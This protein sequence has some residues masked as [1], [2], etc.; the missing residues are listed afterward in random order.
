DQSDWSNKIAPCSGLTVSWKVYKEFALALHNSKTVTNVTSMEECQNLCIADLDLPCL[1]VDFDS[2]GL[3]CHLSQSS[4]STAADYLLPFARF[5]HA[6][7]YCPDDP[8]EEETVSWTSTEQRLRG[9]VVAENYDVWSLQEC[10]NLCLK[11]T[12][13]DGIAYEETN[14]VCLLMAMLTINQFDIEAPRWISEFYTCENGSDSSSS[15]EVDSAFVLATFAGPGEDIFTCDFLNVS[16]QNSQFQYNVLWN[17]NGE[18]IS[19]EA[20][21]IFTLPR[22]FSDIS[23]G[24]MLQCGVSVCEVENC[25][26]TRGPLVFSNFYTA[27]IQ[28]NTLRNQ[29][30]GE[31]EMGEVIQVRATAPPYVLCRGKLS[32]SDDCSIEVKFSFEETS[33]VSSCPNGS[34]VAQA[35]LLVLKNDGKSN[36]SLGVCSITL[37]NDDWDSTFFVRAKG[38]FDQLFDGD[39]IIQQTTSVDYLNST[40]TVH[41]EQVG[42]VQLTIVDKDNGA[43]CSSVTDPHIT[44]FDGRLFH[45]FLEGEFILYKHQTLPYEVRSFYR[46]CADITDVNDP[47]ASCNCAVAIRAGDD[48]VIFDKCGPTGTN[49]QTFYPM[50]AHMFRK[51]ILTPGF[52]VISKYEGRQYKVIFPSGLIVFVAS[53]PFD[54]L[55]ILNIWIKPSPTDL[56][57]TEGLCGPYDL[58]PSNDLMFQNGTVYRDEGDYH[59]PIDYM[60]SWRVDPADTLYTGSCYQSDDEDVDVDSVVTFCQCTNSGENTCAPES[61]K[62]TCPYMEINEVDVTMRL[63]RQASFPLKCLGIPS[64]IDDL[65]L[66]QFEENYGLQVIEPKSLWENLCSAELEEYDVFTICNNVPGIRL[67]AIIE[68]CG[69][70]FLIEAKVGWIA[71]ALQNLQMECQ[72]QLERNVSLW[73]GDPKRPPTDLFCIAQCGNDVTVGTC[74]TGVCQCVNGN[75]GDDC[76]VKTEEPPQLFYIQNQGICDL[77]DENCDQISIFANNILNTPSLACHF[78]KLLT[79]ETGSYFSGEGLVT[80]DASFLTVNEMSCPISETGTYSVQISNDGSTLS[81]ISYLFVY[82]SVCFDCFSDNQTCV[83]KTSACLINGVCYENGEFDPSSDRLYCNPSLNIFD[84][85]KANDSCQGLPVKWLKHGGPFQSDGSEQ[86]CKDTC[87]ASYSEN[88]SSQCLQM[89]LVSSNNTC[90]L[91]N[92]D[93]RLGEVSLTPDSSRYEWLCD[94][95][96]CSKRKLLWTRQ[97]GYGIPGDGS[98]QFTGVASMSECR[99]LC[100][101]ETSFLCRSA[102]LL[103]R[104]GLCTLFSLG[105]VEAGSNFVRWSGTIFEEWTCETG[106]DNPLPVE[107]PTATIVRD[108]LGASDDY[109]LECQFTVPASNISL[110]ANIDWIID[111]TIVQKAYAWTVPDEENLSYSSHMNRSSLTNLPPGTKLSCGVSL[112]VNDSCADTLGG[113]RQSNT[114]LLGLEMTSMEELTV[115]EGG[116][117]VVVHIV[118]S[119]PPAFFCDVAS[120]ASDCSILIQAQVVPQPDNDLA[121]PDPNSALSVSEI[122]LGGSDEKSGSVYC[123]QTITFKN[124]KEGVVIPV[125]ARQDRVIDGDKTR[126]ISVSGSIRNGGQEGSELFSVPLPTTQVTIIDTDKGAVCVAMTHAHLT[127]FGGRNYDLP[128]QGEFII[129]EHSMLQS[130]VRAFYQSCGDGKEAESSAPCVCSVAVRSQDDVVLI[131]RCSSFEDGEPRLLKT[132]LYQKGLLSDAM[133]VTRNGGG[134]AYEIT[135]PSGT[136]ILV[137]VKEDHLNVFVQ[138]SGADLNNTRGLCGFYDGGSDFVLVKRDGTEYS[139]PGQRPDE[140]SLSWRVQPSESIYSGYCNSSSDIQDD[141]SELLCQCVGSSNGTCQIRSDLCGCP[142]QPRKLSYSGGV[143]ITDELQLRASEPL[144]GNG[145]SFFE[146]D[147]QEI[148]QVMPWPTAS[149]LSSA[150]ATSSCNLAFT[151]NPILQRCQPI[152]SEEL[153]TLIDTCVDDIQVSDNPL[154]SEA[155]MVSVATSLCYFKAQTDMNYWDNSTGRPEPDQSLLGDVCFNQCSDSGNCSQGLCTCGNSSIGGADCSIDVAE[156]PKIYYLQNFGLCDITQSSCD[157]VYVTGTTFACSES[158]TCILKPVQILEGI[159]KSLGEPLVTKAEYFSFNEVTCPLPSAGSYSV[160]VSN[161]NSSFSDAAIFTLYHPRCHTCS[162]S[163]VCSLTYESCFIDNECYLYGEENPSNDT[164]VC[165]NYASYDSWTVR[166]DY[167]YLRGDPRLTFTYS[168]ETEIAQFKCQFTVPERDGVSYLISWKHQDEIVAKVTADNTTSNFSSVFIGVEEISGFALNSKISCLLTA[169]FSDDCNATESPAEESN[170]FVAEITIIDSTV[171][172]VEGKGPGYIQVKSSVPPHL[173]CSMV[174]SDSMSNDTM[175]SGDIFNG[176]IFSNETM[177]SSDSDKSLCQVM[178]SVDFMSHPEDKCPFSAQLRRQLIFP[179]YMMDDNQTYGGDCGVPFRTWPEP[180]YVPILAAI[181][182]LVDGDVTRTVEVSAS[183]EYNKTVEM[184]QVVGQQ[185]VEVIDRDTP[186]LCK[187]V[188]DPHITAFD[189][190]KYDVFLEGEFVL[191]KH[192]SMKYE[193]RSFYRKCGNGGA[194]CNCAVTVR[195]LDD[196]VLLDACGPM[197]DEPSPA[198]AVTLYRNGP[199]TKNLRIKQLL[200]G[201]K[202]EV[203]LPTGT[204]VKVITEGYY[205]NV[206]VQASANDFNSSMGLCG[207]YNG[208]ENDDIMT[209]KGEVYTGSEI[210][211][212]KFSATWRVNTS[213]SHYRGVC[214]GEFTDFEESDDVFCACQAERNSTMNETSPECG[215]DLNLYRCTDTRLESERMNSGIDVTDKYIAESKT[216]LCGNISEPAFDFDPDFVPQEATWKASSNWT[217]AK[218]YEFCTN[219]LTKSEIG[220]QC[221]L[222]F[223]TDFN[224]TVESCVKD[225]Q[226]T[227]DTQFAVDSLTNLLEQCL[228]SITRVTALWVNGEPDPAFTDFICLNNCNDRGNCSNGLCQCEKGFGGVDCSVDLTAVPALNL[229]LPA[230]PCNVDDDDCNTITIVG[231]PFVESGDLACVLEQADHKNL[232]SLAP[233]DNSI[234]DVMAKFITF[235]RIKCMLPFTSSFYVSVRNSISI[236]SRAV[237]RQ[238]YSPE[239]YT[240]EDDTCSLEPK[241]CFIENECYRVYDVNPNNSSLVCDPEKYLSLWTNRLDYPE[242]EVTPKL[243]TRFNKTASLFYFGCD[244]STL[245][246]NDTS[247]TVFA[248]WFMDDIRIAEYTITGNETSYEISHEDEAF[249]GLQYHSEIYCGLV[250]CETDR[251]NT[252]RSPLIKS[253]NFKPEIKV[254]GKSELQITEG[255]DSKV[256]R[257]TANF[258]PVVFCNATSPAPCEIIVPTQV[259]E[260]DEDVR[261]PVSNAVLPQVVLDWKDPVTVGQSA[262]LA[263]GC[264]A[265]LTNSNWNLVHSVGVKA[266]SD[267]VTDGD[268]KRSLVITAR[269]T[270]TVTINVGTVELKV[271]DRDKIAICQSINDPHMTTADGLYYNNFYTGE[272]IMYQHNVLPYEVRTFYRKCTNGV[273]SCNCA[274]SVRSGVDVF[275]VDRCGA[276]NKITDRGQ[277]PLQGDFFLN[278]PAT[279][280]LYVNQIDG[281]LMYEIFFPTGTTVIITS[282]PKYINVVIKMSSSDYGQTAGLCGNFDGDKENDLTTR[283]GE[284]VTMNRVDEFSLSWRVKREESLYGG[285]CGT[286]PTTSPTP[287][288]EPSFCSCG[289]LNGSSCSSDSYLQ[290]CQGGFIQLSKG[291]DMTAYFQ[292]IAY[293]LL[294]TWTFLYDD[295]YVPQIP[296][297]PTPSG[298][299]LANATQFCKDYIHASPSARACV[300][301]VDGLDLNAVI[302]GCI[303]DIL[304]L[305]TEEFAKSAVDNIVIRCLIH[306]EVN[307]TLWIRENQSVTLNMDVLDKVCPEDCNNQGNCSKGTCICEDGFGGPACSVDLTSPPKIDNIIITRGCDLAFV[308]KCTPVFQY[309]SNFENSTDLTCHIRDLIITDT[310]FITLDEVT[311]PGMFI[312]LN[313]LF[314]NISGHTSYNI[315]VSSNRVNTSQPL[316]FYI[317]NSN[318][319]TC[320]AASDS[321]TFV[322]DTCFIKNVCYTLGQLSPDNSTESCQPETSVWKFSPTPAYPVVREPNLISSNLEN[323]PYFEFICKLSD[324]EICRNHIDYEI[325]WQMTNGSWGQSQNIGCGDESKIS[326]IDLEGFVYGQSVKCRVRSCF[327]AN[328]SDTY[329]PWRESELS[330]KIEVRETSLTVS[331]YGNG[332][333]IHVSSP[334]PPG[335]FCGNINNWSNCT[336]SIS[337]A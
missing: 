190:K 251:C 5:E 249:V 43:L 222:V 313:T 112:C 75:G 218:A 72:L 271:L 281:G 216:P 326:L 185:Q 152:L 279:G 220:L 103:R 234:Y 248:Q 26:T 214:P 139:R 88:N 260:D 157:Q 153:Q 154:W 268:Q 280:G 289:S 167:P 286:A 295:T 244:W 110:Q 56:G 53:T 269:I 84:W 266:V 169:C 67:S 324:D 63:E 29:T 197:R 11:N 183:I 303:D 27:E 77:R 90:I 113:F 161:N 317:Y 41:S 126:T 144:C 306:L 25:E 79:N 262:V 85:T 71:A 270:Q 80:E 288:R 272:F 186:S 31:G 191:W 64:L 329:S 55:Q 233:R 207:N 61:D 18:F 256:V 204:E 74:D 237:L 305:D 102:Q 213:Q 261:C 34:T 259:L 201:R 211:P 276:D 22:N 290:S 304:M 62:F 267:G 219:Y 69:F 68:S 200:E 135:L 7:L 36:S 121:C 146:Y 128:Y 1:S 141:K 296:T 115:V 278:G 238:V 188:N 274:V 86:A 118:S 32:Q 12:S 301:E 173:L 242:I 300:E 163:G 101:Q 170:E 30:I 337:V 230:L 44:T 224:Q 129:Y 143:D 292:E 82:D 297:W 253:E 311:S 176:T 23:N 315:A 282:S 76:S 148:Y 258:P 275:R 46:R 254:T 87:L 309:G 96:P 184:V 19:E 54:D 334:F 149:N 287:V 231:G 51:G 106:A 192:T 164:L 151:S 140:F 93:I 320:D 116:A 307:T 168:E 181:D 136:V 24:D 199:L 95:N 332:G 225:I 66:F 206:W 319:V 321:C 91:R 70:D 39:H 17:L 198:F 236:T 277:T 175:D 50:T 284:L 165:D 28:V 111:E 109:T 33:Q 114:I 212:N 182:S 196:V 273:A 322:K 298:R 158:L 8:C 38:I 210:Q 147:A 124:W 293:P 108:Q 99:L 250:A 325:S 291:V 120:S 97:P 316:N 239:C 177:P 92:D 235:Q 247:L 107:N 314:C 65:P 20:T 227:D 81:D 208:E 9:T 166:K 16:G 6:D 172:V 299:T 330:S 142:L 228:S 263:S 327:V 252:T 195:A 45:N 240:C 137:Q 246:N 223:E 221:S 52:R 127:T 243:T 13:C 47:E 335:M 2:E 21:D 48:V 302:Q 160:Q 323:A 134:L 312:N 162:S 104:G 138:A 255:E 174:Y 73:E 100:L 37:V 59:Q 49:V 217:E 78:I 245:I 156:S 308:P 333:K 283:N 229:L 105:Q 241:Y 264:G 130:E 180:V 159:T 294:C 125:V 171:Q 232:S 331:E 178:V 145:K 155:S 10:R 15:F 187:S 35:A 133:R 215:R 42:S 194:S 202:Y 98:R 226:I 123:G 4:T 14:G 40:Q 209:Q 205:L 285:F 89:E 132:K 122:V 179:R 265:V 60:R 94:N 336:L 131:D 57:H 257:I 3:K 189:G 58:D 83:Q 150:E 310:G 203:I 328:C 119:A 193:V 117:S 318:C